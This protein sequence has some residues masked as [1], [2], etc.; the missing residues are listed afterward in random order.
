MWLMKERGWPMRHDEIKA[1][2]G[3]PPKLPLDFSCRAKNIDGVLVYV[4]SGEGKGNR[5]GHRVMAIC[6]VCEKHVAAGRLNQHK[7]V[8]A[9]GKDCHANLGAWVDAWR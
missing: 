9:V 8:H 2:L 6:P 5:S 7:K 3:L 1:A 4:T